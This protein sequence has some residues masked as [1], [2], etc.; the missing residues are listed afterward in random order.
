MIIQGFTL[1]AV[2]KIHLLTLLNLQL[3]HHDKH[4]TLLHVFNGIAMIVIKE[5]SHLILHRDKLRHHRT[6]SYH[7]QLVASLAI[8]A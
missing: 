4:Q 5:Q 6:L 7:Y 2:A 3:L 8:S 1:P